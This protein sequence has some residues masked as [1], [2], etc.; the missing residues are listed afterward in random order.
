MSQIRFSILI[1]FDNEKKNSRKEI[2]YLLMF[3]DRG[4][5]KL[6]FIYIYNVIDLIAT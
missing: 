5:T 1:V 4:Y 2:T 6:Y 3:Q